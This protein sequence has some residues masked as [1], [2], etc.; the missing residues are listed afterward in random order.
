MKDEMSDVVF[1]RARHVISENQR[2]MDAVLAL[3]KDDFIRLGEL[4]FQ[5]HESLRDDYE[6]SCPELDLL[7]EFAQE[8]PG[9]L[10]AR[11]T[12]AGFGGSGIALV[13]T[14]G[15]AVFK[16]QLLEDA[17]KQ[18]FPRPIFYEVNVGEGTQ[19]YLLNEEKE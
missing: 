10:G 2:V 17:E 11:L 5:S 1:R 13:K 4:I 12:G 18:G 14:E 8:F 7:Y 15:I 6:V 3:E 19:S 16:E 9:C